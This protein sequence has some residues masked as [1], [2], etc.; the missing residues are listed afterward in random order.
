MRSSLVVCVLVLVACAKSDQPPVDT[1]KATMAPAAMKP[2]PIT[3][4]DLAGTWDA[5]AMPAA[6]DTVVT[7]LVLTAT[8]TK[9]GWKMKLPNGANPSVKIVSVGGDSIVSDAGPFASATRKG[10]QVTVHSIFRLR[11]GKLVGTTH[12]KYGNGDTA[13]LRLNGTK[14]AAP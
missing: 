8:S 3:L 6:K 5:T 9:D 4:A 1:A 7:T 14:R 13:T 2:A 12:A 10:Q 11:D